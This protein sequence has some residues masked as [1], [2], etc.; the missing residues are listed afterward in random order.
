MNSRLTFAIGQASTDWLLPSSPRTLRWPTTYRI[1]CAPERSH[2]ASIS[3]LLYTWMA[4]VRMV[5]RCGSIAMTISTSPPHSEDTSIR[6][7]DVRRA[8][9]DSTTIWKSSVLP[10]KRRLEPARNLILFFQDRQCYYQF[11]HI[12]N[13][14]FASHVALIQ[15][16]SNKFSENRLD[17]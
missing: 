16:R 3:I 1:A 7:M 15:N 14:D 17:D 9:T 12:L 4:N 6:A 13:L 2:F 5:E 8:N 11:N 10:S